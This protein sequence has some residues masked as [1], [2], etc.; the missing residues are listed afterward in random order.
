M[1]RHTLA[2]VISL[3]TFVLLVVG[4]AVGGLP[5]YAIVVALL[6]VAVVVPLAATAHPRS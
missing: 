1:S 4:L 3:P 2:L 5:G 6:G